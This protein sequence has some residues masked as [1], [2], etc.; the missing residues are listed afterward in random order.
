MLEVTHMALQVA[1]TA[2]K[3][4][5]NW[6]SG[7]E[8]YRLLEAKRLLL[9]DSLRAALSGQQDALARGIEPGFV[10]GYLQAHGDDDAYQVL[11]GDEDDE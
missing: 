4:W 7:Q 9:Q 10:A 5:Q 8:Q 6:K 1:H 3:L 11:F 2:M